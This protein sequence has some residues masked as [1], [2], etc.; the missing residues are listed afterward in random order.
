MPLNISTVP[1]FIFVVTIVHEV[2][3]THGN[4]FASQVPSTFHLSLDWFSGH[5]EAP[6]TTKQPFTFS[7]TIRDR[8][9][10][11]IIGKTYR[12]EC[13]TGNDNHKAAKLVISLH[14]MTSRADTG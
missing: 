11:L 14:E 5:F 10:V 2:S 13:S 1:S 4:I 12:V 3:S 9:A 8:V 7:D 6:N